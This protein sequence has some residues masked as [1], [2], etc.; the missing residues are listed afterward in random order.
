MSGMGHNRGPSLEP[1][2][3][4]RRHAWTKARND[5]LPRLPLEIVRI[6]VARAKR[7]GLDYRTYA[8]I[9]ATSGRDIVAFLYSGNALGLRPGRVEIAA[10]L[11]DSLA[12]IDAARLAAVY[13]PA[14]PRAVEAANPG[15]IDMAGRAPGFTETW[16]ATRDQLGTLLT[17][18][19]VPRD[20]VVLVAATAV[21][22][23]WCAAAGLAGL[24]SAERLG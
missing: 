11:R 21:E 8:T 22:R 4:F 2:F 3:G 12:D 18:A 19:A 7:L 13:A 24:L 20:G 5:L 6:R 1:G 23:D 16:R 14:H 15:V 10:D 9:R 17:Q